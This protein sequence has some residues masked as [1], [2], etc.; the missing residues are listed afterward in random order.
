VVKRERIGSG[1]REGFRGRGLGEEVFIFLKPKKK[2]DEK[3]ETHRETTEV[4]NHPKRPHVGLRHLED[5]VPVVSS[6][7]SDCLLRRVFLRLNLGQAFNGEEKRGKWG[8]GKG[9]RGE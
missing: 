7:V 4:L 3:G 1:G 6:A 5:V 8:G 9:E 2:G